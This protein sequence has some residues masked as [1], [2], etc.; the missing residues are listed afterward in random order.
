MSSRSRSARR[1]TQRSGL[2]RTLGGHSDGS[3]T[4]VRTDTLMSGTFDLEDLS[5]MDISENDIIAQSKLAD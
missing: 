5:N 4:N 1:I 3:G 2:G